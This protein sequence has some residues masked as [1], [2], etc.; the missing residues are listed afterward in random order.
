MINR[1]TKILVVDDEAAMREVLEMRLQEW[2]FEVRL[3][4]DG[5]E[6]KEQAEIVRPR[7]GHFGRGHAA[8]LGS[9]SAPFAEVGG[10]RPADHPGDG[11]GE[12]RCGGR[13]DEGGAQDFITKP[14]DYPK[15]KC[16]P[17]LGREGH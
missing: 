16:D 15:L 9:G 12:H 6:G 13:S 7:R 3:A 2:G 17:R 4:A 5:F 10:C 14:I 11:P 1:K 8:A